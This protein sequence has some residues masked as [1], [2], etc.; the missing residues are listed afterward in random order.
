M[1]WQ[2][3][4]ENNKPIQ[5]AGLAIL[6]GIISWLSIIW[7]VEDS[8]WFMLPDLL[9]SAVGSYFGIHTAHDPLNVTPAK[10]IINVFKRKPQT[11]EK[12]K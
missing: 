3:A 12:R 7:I 6:L 9:G 10:I 8:Y 5:G 1:R 2:T 11:L 4:R